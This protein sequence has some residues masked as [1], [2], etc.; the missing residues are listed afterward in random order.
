MINQ[1]CIRV[2]KIDLEAL[3]VKV[4]EIKIGEVVIEHQE[5]EELKQLIEDK[6]EESGFKIIKNQ[7]KKLVEK[8]RLAVFDMV[9]NTTFNAM[10][11]NSDFLVGKFNKSYQHLSTLFSRHEGITLEKFIINQRI[12]K[13]KALIFEGEMSLSE[14]AFITGYSSVQYL[15]TQ[16]KTISGI[17]VTEFKTDPIKYMSK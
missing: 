5:S 15:S 1:C 13:V 7:D 10:V 11:R 4:I 17:S 2:V 14:I 9:H 6:L 16:F 3:G 12:E 8:I